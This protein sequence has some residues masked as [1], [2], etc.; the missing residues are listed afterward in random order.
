MATVPT[1]Y[2]WADGDIATAARMNE[3]FR[4]PAQFLAD[5]RPHAFARQLV[6]KTNMTSGAYTLVTWDFEDV[7]TDAGMDLTGEYYNVNTAGWYLVSACINYAANTTGQRGIK[8]T[9]AVGAGGEVDITGCGMTKATNVTTG[10]YIQVM[11]L[12]AVND[13]IR[14]RGWQDSGVTITTDLN[15]TNFRNETSFFDVSWQ[16]KSHLVT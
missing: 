14:V 11:D 6:S 16:G 12:F 8:I 2:T 9:R 3:N 7:D 13:R 15:Y 10:V 4:D 1:M 5:T